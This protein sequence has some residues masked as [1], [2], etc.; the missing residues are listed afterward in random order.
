MTETGSSNLQ[1]LADY[2]SENQDPILKDW[3]E[4]LK[5]EE[6][7]I[8]NLI[9]FSREKFY[10]HIP[11]FLEQ[12]N[13]A[14][15]GKIN[16]AEDVATEHGALRWQYGF[17]L[18]EVTKEWNQLHR[19]L[20]EHVGSQSL[21]P[22][23]LNKAHKIIAE[24][25]NKGIMYS[26]NEYYQ[27]QSQQAEARMHNLEAALKEKKQEDVNHSQN[28]RQTTHDLRGIL[29]TLKAGFT[30]LEEEKEELDG[31][32][33]ELINQ[34][35]LA[36]DTLSELIIDLLDLFRLEAG[37]EEVNITSINAAV[38]LSDLCASLQP[39]ADTEN[40]DLRCSG[41]VS[42]MVQSDGS[43]LQ[44]IA[45]NLLINSLKYTQKGYV[46]MSWEQNGDDEWLLKICDTGPGLKS[47]S[48]DNAQMHGEGIG[49]LIVRKLCK[50][51]NAIITVETEPD[52]GTVFRVMFP[53]NKS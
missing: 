26:I 10:D 44:R 42:L 13:K 16:D 20:M 27:H 22:S 6:D 14:L 3:E 28:M 21:N 8:S 9:S 41:E 49:L 46:E 43:K 5:N 45:Q 30:L 31:D 38:V 24:E 29:T 18:R 35:A 36:A 39:L 48:N 7:Q 23:E 34:M 4:K 17:N 51:L 40:I 15:V 12:L 37:R 47:D 25:V 19:V 2:L 32:T 52:E 33:N 50:L 53:L 1:P 11:Q